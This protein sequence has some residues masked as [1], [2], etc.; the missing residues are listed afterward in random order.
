MYS[1]GATLL[2]L[3]FYM[4][5]HLIAYLSILNI[6]YDTKYIIRRKLVAE[7]QCFKNLEFQSCQCCRLGV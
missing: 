5:Q 7:I 2:F 1:C 6:F 4:F 3:V